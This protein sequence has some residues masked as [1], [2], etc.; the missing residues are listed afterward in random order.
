V[1]W[2]TVSVS[3]RGR[4]PTARR[5]SLM[6]ISIIKLVKVV[7]RYT[8]TPCRRNLPLRRPDLQQREPRDEKRDEGRREERWILL[9]STGRAR[10]KGGSCQELLRVFYATLGHPARRRI[11]D[12]LIQCNYLAGMPRRERACNARRPPPGHSF[13]KE[14]TPPRV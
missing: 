12:A 14:E 8:G 3:A 13:R 1:R 11:G 10:S 4:Q 2:P 5:A 6:K 7:S 9:C